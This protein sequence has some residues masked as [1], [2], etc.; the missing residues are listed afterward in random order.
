[1]KKKSR[2][3]EYETLYEEK[4]YAI[5]F[6]RKCHCEELFI[7]DSRYFDIKR[8]DSEI[9]KKA[10]EITGKRFLYFENRLPTS[11]PKKHSKSPYVAIPEIWRMH[12][13]HHKEIE[14]DKE[15][16]QED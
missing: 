9:P 11:H 10:E 6:C 13:T 7:K 5:I 12:I 3:K 1:M 16:I 2:S 8:T 14:D 4:D 15:V